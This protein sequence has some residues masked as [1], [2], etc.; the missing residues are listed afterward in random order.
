MRK[1]FMFHRVTPFSRAT[2]CTIMFL[3]PFDLTNWYYNID[4][5]QHCGQ[6]AAVH[7]QCTLIQTVG[8]MTQSSMQTVFFTHW[9]LDWFLMLGLCLDTRQVGHSQQKHAKTHL[10]RNSP[11][12][13][14]SLRRSCRTSAKV[15]CEVREVCVSFLFELL[16]LQLSVEVNWWNG[17]SSLGF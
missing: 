13:W 6:Q 4:S 10:P 12:G 5:V 9:I 11:L 2:R 15:H 3:R 17:G 16:Q 8:R 7:P 1:L 14:N